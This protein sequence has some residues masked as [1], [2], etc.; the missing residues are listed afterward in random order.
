MKI[1]KMLLFS[2]RFQYQSKIIRVIELKKKR[3]NFLF[4]AVIY[5]PLSILMKILTLYYM[6]YLILA[7][8]HCI[9]LIQN[10]SRHTICRKIFIKL[11]RILKL[12]KDMVD[13]STP[14]NKQQVKKNMVNTARRKNSHSCDL[15]CEFF[16]LHIQYGHAIFCKVSCVLLK[17]NIFW[18]HDIFSSKNHTIKKKRWKNVLLVKI[19]RYVF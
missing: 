10:K 7:M 9:C 3:I 5:F 15:C 11:P 16:R 12:I 14:L 17:F 13:D 1:C 6:Y 2:N 8:Y 19:Q 18:F 4:I